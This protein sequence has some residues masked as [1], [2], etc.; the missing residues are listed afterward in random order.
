VPKKI[1]IVTE[2]FYP[3]EF[4]IN[5]VALSWKDKGYSVDILTLVPTYPVGVIFDGYKNKI[6]SI[7]FF[8][9][10]KIYRV[11]AVTGY[12]NSLFK[13]ILKYL[14]FMILGS[15]IAIFIGR[16]YD[17][18]FGFNM[19]ALTNM[20]P[21]VLIRK[22]YKK[23]LT[24]WTLDIWPESIYAYGFKKTKM[25]SLILDYF[26]KFIYHNIDN[27]ALSGK[28]FESFLRVY[29]KQQ[30][31]YYYL[32]NWADDINLNIEPAKLGEDS[33][34]HFTFA[35]NIGK[36]QNLAN[37]IKAFSEMDDGYLKRSQLNIIGSG[38]ALSSLKS[39]SFNKNIIFHGLKPRNEMS[40]YF[41]AS[42]FLIV[43]LID[44]PIFSVTIPAKT[45]TYIA[46]KK[47]ILAFING[48]TAEIIKENN[49]GFIANPS[50]ID[51]MKSTFMLAIDTDNIRL[52]EFSKNFEK[53]S[54][55]TFNKDIIINRLLELTTSGAI[56]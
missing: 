28:G 17:F 31:S 30:Q 37:I 38:S 23:P 21:A 5:D 27:I 13:K 12:R 29:S 3:E 39:S 8:Q 33:K 1:L 43:S 36:V 46:A 47:P 49:I 26:V 48:D 51:E 2:C 32:P 45:Q 44:R 18:V 14:N 40:A 7:N 50:D 4:K 10:I 9:G 25:L 11:F 55:Q 54:N 56:K 53:L 15:I 52:K 42:D 20:V 24:F 35:G 6:F 19:S 22:L 34:V 41:L 16:K